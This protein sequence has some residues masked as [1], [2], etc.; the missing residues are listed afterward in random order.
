M[1]SIY[2]RAYVRRCSPRHDVPS[3]EREELLQLVIHNT[4]AQTLLC[5]AFLQLL[6]LLKEEPPC[7][8]E[9]WW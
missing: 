2:L 4:D 3:V 6:L 7:F 9:I 5:E 8:Q 1:G